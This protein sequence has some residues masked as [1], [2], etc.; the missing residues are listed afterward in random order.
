MLAKIVE[1]FTQRRLGDPVTKLAVLAHQITTGSHKEEADGDN[2]ST[3]MTVHDDGLLTPISNHHKC[4]MTMKG[5]A[6]YL[7]NIGCNLVQ[8]HLREFSGQD[9][10]TMLWQKQRR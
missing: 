4:M 7:V 8:N 10:P 2:L 9:P 3:S 5:S 6:D 1:K